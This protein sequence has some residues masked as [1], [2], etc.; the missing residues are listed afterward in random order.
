MAGFA[1]SNLSNQVCEILTFGSSENRQFS[2]VSYK[3][4]NRAPKKAFVP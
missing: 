1:S 4:F 2:L 3:L